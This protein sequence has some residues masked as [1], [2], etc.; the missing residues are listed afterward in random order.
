MRQVRTAKAPLLG[1]IEIPLGKLQL[2]VGLAVFIPLPVLILLAEI[3]NDRQAVPTGCIGYLAYLALI[4]AHEFGHALLAWLLDMKVVAIEL[5]V[6]HGWCWFIPSKS[7]LRNVAVY[8]GGVLAQLL[9]FGACVWL[10]FSKWS[11]EIRPLLWVWGPWNLYILVQNL[12][13]RF[14]LDG[15]RAWRLF[16]VA[17][18]LFRVKMNLPVRMAGVPLRDEVDLASYLLGTPEL[19]GHLQAMGVSAEPLIAGLAGL[20]QEQRGTLSGLMGLVKQTAVMRIPPGRSS[21]QTPFNLFSVLIRYGRPDIRHA[22]EGAGLDV[23]ALLFRIAHGK[24]ENEFVPSQELDGVVEVRMVNDDFTPMELVVQLLVKHLRVERP[25]AVSH[26]VKVHQ[27]GAAIVRLCPLMEAK[28]LTTA[29]NADARL[30][31][32]PLLCVLV[33]EGTPQAVTPIPERKSP[34]PWS[35]QTVS[36]FARSLAWVW[37]MLS[38]LIVVMFLVILLKGKELPPIR[39]AGLALSLGFVYQTML[40]GHVAVT[41]RAPRTWLPWK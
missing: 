22:L 14:P 3:L 17:L 27:A 12:W 28:A 40:F 19:R 6:F 26:M 13:P 18:N 35:G 9:L 2:R 4:L 10:N 34:P 39:V 15:W 7:E 37:V 21:P 30:D 11:G 5:H 25:E 24:S 32:A 29:L 8:W 1:A 20:G 41:G 38:A 16:P 33:P 36:G 23:R 31:Y